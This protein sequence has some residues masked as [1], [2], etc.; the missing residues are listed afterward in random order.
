[1][2]HV[3][4]PSNLRHADVPSGHPVGEVCEEA[5]TLSGAGYAV[6]VC[7]ALDASDGRFV[8][9][10]AAFVTAPGE[11]GRLTTRVRQGE[12][13]LNALGEPPMAER[14]TPDPTTD[15][16]LAGAEAE[17]AREAAAEAARKVI[18]P[19]ARTSGKSSGR[20]SATKASPKPA[21]STSAG[22]AKPATA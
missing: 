5:V 9:G 7:R 3:L 1:V 20:S 4:S 18:T 6:P 15:D 10:L 21:S 12:R 17:A 8:T 14:E 13:D 22:A 11:R 16:A 2:D 19:K